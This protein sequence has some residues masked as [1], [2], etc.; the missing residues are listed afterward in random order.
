MKKNQLLIF[1]LLTLSLMFTLSACDTAQ[2]TET[3]ET[4]T[5]FEDFTPIVSATGEVVPKQS[6]YLSVK[7]GGVVAEVLVEEGDSV[8][9]GDILIRLEGTEHLQAAVAATQF[10]LVNA[11]VAMMPPRKDSEV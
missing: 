7:T 2:E 5:S 9:A 10:E 1:I 3:P 11:Q 4:E 8:K 6:A